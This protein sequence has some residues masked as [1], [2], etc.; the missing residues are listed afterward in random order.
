MLLIFSSWTVKYPQRPLPSPLLSHSIMIPALPE[1]SLLTTAAWSTHRLNQHTQGVLTQMPL[2]RQNSSVTLLVTQLLSSP[3]SISLCAAGIRSD[4]CAH[5][6]SELWCL[7]L[8]NVWSEPV[9]LGSNLG[10]QI[11]FLCELV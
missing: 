10:S 3:R 6:L 8:K 1:Y 2:P 4:L 7:V 5:L 11:C 9:G